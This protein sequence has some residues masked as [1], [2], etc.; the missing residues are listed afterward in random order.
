MLKLVV[1][2]EIKN[3]QEGSMLRFDT[4]FLELKESLIDFAQLKATIERMEK[5]IDRLSR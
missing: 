3:S 5:K 2:T 4:K 1:N